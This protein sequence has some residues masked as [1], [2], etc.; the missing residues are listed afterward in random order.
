MNMTTQMV[1]IANRADESWVST[2]ATSDDN[3]VEAL[4][5]RPRAGRSTSTDLKE[6]SILQL[7]FIF[8][9]LSSIRVVIFTAGVARRLALA[10]IGWSR[11]CRSRW[12]SG[13]TQMELL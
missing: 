3:S 8:V 7:A 9:A 13:M 1:F 5:R 12:L 10:R 6:V 4:Q 2:A 11:L